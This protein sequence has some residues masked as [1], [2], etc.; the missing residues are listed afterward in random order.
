MR[1]LI[2]FIPAFVALLLSTPA[3]SQINDISEIEINGPD[4]VMS[5]TYVEYG[6]TFRDLSGNVITNPPSTGPTDVIWMVSLGVNADIIHNNGIIQEYSIGLNLESIC[7][8]RR[9]D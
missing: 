5:N 8:L 2:L 1:K 3:V 4:A 9:Y 6:L 7:L